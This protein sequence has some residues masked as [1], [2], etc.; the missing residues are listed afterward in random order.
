MTE[1][2]RY[3]A[4]SFVEQS[5]VLKLGGDR[6]RPSYSCTLCFQRLLRVVDPNFT[7]LVSPM[8]AAVS[9]NTTARRAVR[10]IGDGSCSVGSGGAHGE[11]ITESVEK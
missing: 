1:S 10:D 4:R 9:A 3:F 11:N 8:P 6:E 7:L 5:I 2:S